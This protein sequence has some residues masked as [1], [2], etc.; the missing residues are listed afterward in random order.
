MTKWYRPSERLPEHD[1]QVLIRRAER[2]EVAFFD[3]ATGTFNLRDGAA[4][5]K[6]EDLVWMHMIRSEVA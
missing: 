1:E 5:D 3:S 6:T 4:L 2:I